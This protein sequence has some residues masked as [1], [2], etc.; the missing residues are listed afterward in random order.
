M[1]MGDQ[2]AKLRERINNS[3]TNDQNIKKTRIITVTSGKGG[4]GKSN[5]S[6]NFALSLIQQNK[7]VLI[8]DVDVG[9]AN[10]DVLMGFTARKTI[11]QMIEKD[12]SIWDIVEEGPLGLQFIAGGSGFTQL[13]HL[14]EDRLSRL[15]EQLSAIQGH[16][17]YIILDT[18]AGLSP[19]SLRYILAADDVILVTT[20]EPTSYTDAYAVL[21]M[22]H[23]H[24]PAVHFKLVINR[25]SSIK[26]GRQTFNKL[27]LVANQF[28]NKEVSCLGFISDDSKVTQAVKKQSP[29]LLEFPES[30][31]SLGIKEIT[32]SFLNTP[33][34]NEAGIKG[35]L[36]RMFNKLS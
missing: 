20:P 27:H 1:P 7:K 6:L 2:A 24:D 3:I 8:F 4:V 10:I 22:V 21:K 18:G 36:K 35:F 30:Q 29:F 33:V 14:D 11:F 34:E 25:C 9:L 17:D 19:E 5:F 13:F 26:E 15:F 16:V 31:A 12:L 32:A 28:L 23:L